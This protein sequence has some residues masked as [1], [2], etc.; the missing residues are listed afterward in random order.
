[1][2]TD[3]GDLFPDDPDDHRTR[4]VEAGTVKLGW[5]H[6][7]LGADANYD[8][9][10]DSTAPGV[11]PDPDAMLTKGTVSY[12]QGV[13]TVTGSGEG[14]LHGWDQGSLVYMEH[15]IEGD[16]TFVAKVEKLEMTNG[17]ALNGA[18]EALLNVRQ[19]LGYKAPTHSIIA[20]ASPGKYMLMARFFWE[21]EKKWWHWPAWPDRWPDHR[22]IP[23][24]NKIE[25]RGKTITV[26]S[27]SDG[28]SWQAI[29]DNDPNR[30]WYPFKLEAMPDARYV[31]LVCSARNDR[32]YAPLTRLPG[33]SVDC[34]DPASD[35]LRAAARCV[36][37]N[38]SITQP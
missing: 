7:N 27:S 3:S 11:C 35:V 15:P 14:F 4:Q 19:D 25:V 37:S 21:G 23:S 17:K 5:L 22:P 8:K 9:A 29:Q 20:G 36:F 6:V 32:N 38:V 13:W 26:S 34:R 18:A 2:P 10:G 30:D 24:W 1:M 33:K 31:G 28:V 16:F 12:E